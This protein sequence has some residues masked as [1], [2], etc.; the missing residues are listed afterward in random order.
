MNKLA[1]RTPAPA[2][3]DVS[4]RTLD[5]A[6]RDQCGT[7]RTAQFDNTATGHRQLIRWLGQGGQAVR[8]VLEATGVYSLDLAV[9]L[10][11]ANRIEV[12][13]VNPR[14]AR[15]FAQACLQRSSTDATMAVA[16][17]EY[18]ARMEFVP[19][20]PPAEPV[21]HLRALARRIVVLTDEWT[22]EQ[23][24]AHAAAASTTTPAVVINDIAVNVRHLQRRRAVLHRQALAM[25]QADSELTRAYHHLTSVRGIAATSAIQ[26]LGELLVLPADMTVRQWVAHSGLDVRHVT[27]GTSV[28]KIPRISKQGNSHLRRALYMPALVAVRHEPHVRAFYEQLLAAGKK[29]LQALVAVMRKL[30]HAIYGMLKTNTDFDGSKFRRL[31]EA[32]AA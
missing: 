5:V 3:V 12:M 4:Q 9:A 16:L 15:Q 21:R 32:K 31:P 24:R 18:A 19:W 26:L 13:V 6:V 25:I 8:V 27:S 2:G 23:N 29:P 14:A 10:H 7:D 17:R 22:S 30:L 1:Q 20:V 11:A 28:H